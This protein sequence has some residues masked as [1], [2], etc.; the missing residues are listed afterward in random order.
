MNERYVFG[1]RHNVL[2]DNA[3]AATLRIL[4]YIAIADLALALISYLFW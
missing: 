4:V 2:G 3:N 1:W